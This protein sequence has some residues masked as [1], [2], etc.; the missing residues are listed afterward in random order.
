MTMT[1]RQRVMAAVARKPVDRIPARF[2]CEP[3]AYLQQVARDLGVPIHGDWFEALQRRMKADL[4]YVD[5]R[6]FR[7]DP[8]GDH[9]NLEPAQTTSDVQRLWPSKWCIENRTLKH[10]REM[11]AQWDAQGVIP[12]V[13]VRLTTLFGMLR[14]M[15]GD[16]LAFMD[17]AED[18]DIARCVLDRMEEYNAAMIDLAFDTLG[19]RLD[20]IYLADELG[21]QMGLMFSPDTIRKQFFSRFARLFERV[22]RRGGKVFYHSCGAIEPLIG[23]LI[24]IGVDILNPIQPRLPGMEP[25]NLAAKFGGK[26][27][28]C[29]GMDMQQLMPLGTPEQIQAEARRYIQCLA[30]GYILDL[31]NILHPDIPTKNVA[32]LY[33]TPRDL[34]PT[35]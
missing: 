19:D 21:M 1:S 22:H 3:G 34:H 4:R 32:A 30:P 29:G 33:D 20:I 16:E 17:L 8:S 13:Q 28:F 35:A 31:A 5:A 9:L 18:N 26:V 7:G 14:R 11:I 10:A 15:R 23:E 27:C 24:D 12:A 6:V 25:E 2:N